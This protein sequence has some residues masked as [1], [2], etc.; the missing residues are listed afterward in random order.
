MTF[1]KQPII[2]VDEIKVNVILARKC[3]VK[4]KN[5]IISIFYSHVSFLL[6]IVCCNTS[7]FFFFI[8][9]TFL[10]EDFL[11]A[12][13]EQITI[14][15]TLMQIWK[16]PYIFVFI[17]KQ[18]PESFALLILRILELFASWFVDFLKSRLIFN[19][20]YYFL[21]FVNKLFTYATC[22]YFKK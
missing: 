11:K 12:S 22:E 20:F 4:A 19:I 3:K 1:R 10:F 21:M 6:Y 7:T 13:K 15:G 5:F 2:A 18:Y 9:I 8:L 14:K 17:W 16:S